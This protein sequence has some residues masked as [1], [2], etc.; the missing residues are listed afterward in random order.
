MY[1]FE[2]LFQIKN[3]LNQKPGLRF[4]TVPYSYT[5]VTLQKHYPQV[6]NYMRQFKKYSSSEEG[7]GAV[8]SE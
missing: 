3:P 1:R 4:S 7:I 5:E 8:K 2:F 6:A